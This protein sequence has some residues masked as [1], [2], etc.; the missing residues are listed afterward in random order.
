[1]EYSAHEL[2]FN[3]DVDIFKNSFWDKINEKYIRSVFFGNSFSI[4]KSIL[5]I[6]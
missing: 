6:N 5:R 2:G 1:M 3:L 4:S